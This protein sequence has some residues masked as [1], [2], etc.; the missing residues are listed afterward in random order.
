LTQEEIGQK[1]RYS[2]TKITRLSAKARDVGIVEI[3]ISST[4]RS[5]IDVEESMHNLFSLKEIIVV[6]TGSGIQETRDGVGKACAAGMEK[7]STI[8]GALR[9]GY[10]NAL[11]TDEQT[12]HETLRFYE[13]ASK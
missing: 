12:A 4:F 11:V 10:I 8:L 13:Q 5:C 7:S 1:P 6:P 9:G 2:R 3:S